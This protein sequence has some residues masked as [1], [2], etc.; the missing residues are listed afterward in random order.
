MHIVHA[1]EDGALAV[2]G[3]LF[4]IGEKDNPFL[5]RFWNDLPSAVTRSV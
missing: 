2:V 4:D 3:V 1:A 5:A